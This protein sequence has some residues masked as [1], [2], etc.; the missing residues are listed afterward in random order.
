[1]QRS[2]STRRATA[3]TVGR[4]LPPPFSASRGPITAARCCHSA[5]RSRQALR[6][7]SRNADQV[8]GHTIMGVS[9]TAGQLT[10]GAHHE[11]DGGVRDL[12]HMLWIDGR[13]KG[14]PPSAA[15][16]LGVCSQQQAEPGHQTG[17]AK[18]DWCKH[19]GT[20]HS[21]LGTVPA[22]GLGWSIV[23]ADRPQGLARISD[24]C[25]WLLLLPHMLT[26]P[27]SDMPELKRGSP[28]TEPT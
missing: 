13:P 18:E 1:M 27:H 20:K 21:Q 8:A 19:L 11:G 25:C 7:E 22:A 5:A 14:R 23:I 15:V 17:C 9:M 24:N 28:P 16:K 4:G 26:P 12:D 10:G 6:Q 2:L 3:S